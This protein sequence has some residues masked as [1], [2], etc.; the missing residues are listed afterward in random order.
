MKRTWMRFGL[1]SVILGSAVLGAFAIGCS[2]DDPPTVTPKKDSGTDTGTD[3]DTGTPVEAGSDAG[4]GGGSQLGKVIAVHGTPGLPD[5][6]FC[7]AAGALDDGSDATLTPLPALPYDDSALPAGIPYPALYAG[8]G[9]PLPS[10]G[11]DLSKVA[12]TVYLIKATKLYALGNTVKS[13]PAG[14]RLT[15]DKLLAK[16][17]AGPGLVEGTDYWKMP[18]IPKGQIARDATSLIVVGGC[19]KDAPAAIQAKC[20]L[21]GKAWDSTNGNLNF[22]AWKVDRVITDATKLGV[23]FAHASSPLG[24]VQG[25]TNATFGAN[26]I[27]LAVDGGNPQQLTQTVALGELKPTAAKSI[28]LPTVGV[29][30]GLLTTPAPITDAG[31]DA[32]PDAAPPGP[33]VTQ[34]PMPW[35][36]IAQLSGT[37]AAAL[38]TVGKNVT[39]VLVG[40]PQAPTYIDPADGGPSTADGGGVF[41]RYSIHYLAFPNDPV[42][43]AL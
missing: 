16:G 40:D 11:A 36:N 15:C 1:A 28:S 29:T 41:N 20:N 2:D 43:Q 35:A 23:Q 19:P 24:A 22:L 26:V 38:F 37:T 34:I 3:P 17:D 9:G 7:F 18:V 33:T 39:F 12:I 6:R 8:T 31:A 13:T 25:A 30:L 14:Q 10:T 27:D 21:P 5:I 4:D 42:I 32:D